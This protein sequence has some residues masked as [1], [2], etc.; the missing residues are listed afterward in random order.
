MNNWKEKIFGELG[1]TYAG[2]S[3]KT[4]KDFGNGKPYI[5][6]MNI[7]A[8]GKINPMFL[9][10]VE[11]LDNE[12]QNAAQKGDIFFTTSSETPEEVGMTSV[13]LD[14]IGECYLNSFCFGFRLYNY[15]DLIPDYAPYLF[16]GNEVRKQIINLG[17]GYTRFNLPKTEL[18]KKLNL[19]LP[20]LPEQK[21]ISEILT[22]VD[23]II[24]KT[25]SAIVKYKAIKHGM[26]H[27]LFTRGIDLQTGKLRPRYEDAPELYKES[28]L[29][30]IPREWKVFDL[31]KVGEFKNGVNKEKAA[32]GHGT[33][34]VNIGDAYL[35]ILDCSILNRVGVSTQEIQD[36]QLVQG[37][38]IFVRSSVKPSGVGYN[39]IFYEYYEPVIFCGFMIRYRLYDK[40]EFIPV[41]YNS[42]FR[43]EDFRNR[44]IGLA[45]VSAN[46]NVNQVSL[47]QLLA[48]HPSKEE[49]YA[50]A[51]RI[52]SIDNKLQTEQTYLQKMQSL[53]KGLMEDLLSGRKRVKVDE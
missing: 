17:Q 1:F 37:D 9:N 44:L 3:G 53:K 18:L 23:A 30:W 52:D 20:P 6:F 19:N 21:K 51:D 31:G 42:Y 34:F 14:D 27:D 4:Q 48:I 10:Y 28:K 24:E 16:R 12:H 5:P 40:D 2:L 36:Y 47:S 49:Q 39:T 35:E 26:L 15:D 32:F 45:T 46:T 50:I 11:V 33:L 43:F 41:F 8:N 7:L 38:I 13:L 29:G 22:S 25:Q